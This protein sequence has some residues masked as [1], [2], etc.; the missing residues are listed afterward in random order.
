MTSFLSLRG[1]GKSFGA[2]RVLDG[3]D[4]DVEPGEF[5]C[6]LGPSGCGKTT[7]LRI[8][9]GIEHADRGRLLL[10]GQDIAGQPPAA[11]GFGVVFQSYALFPNLTAA[12]NIAYGLH[13]T[14]AL[15]REM[16][17]RSR[18]ML[19][20]VGLA[21]HADKYPVQL[22]GGQ[23]QRV[24]LARALAPNPR[25]LLLDEPLSALDAQVRA[26]LRGEIRALQKRLGIVTIMVTHD[27]EEALSMADRVVLMHDG[28]IEQAGSPG[29]LYHRPRTRFVAS[30]VGRMNMLPAT[31]L[32][33]DKVRVRDSELRCAPGALQ[34]GAQATV[35]IRP[36][37]VVVRRFGDGLGANSFAARLLGTEFLG[38]RTAARL[39]CEPLGIEIEAELPPD[40]RT[41]ETLVPSS[42]VHIELPQHAL[43]VLAH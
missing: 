31:V 26:S 36:E 2:S 29:E 10:N 7:L 11:R 24:A 42:M 39:A 30:F 21:A 43:S 8:V 1:I 17:R 13:P 19:D 12:Q 25:L 20:L 9:C 5:V 28:R 40:H 16:A 4:L 15:A 34:V 35:G 14:G 37:H 3:I 6:L 41:D 18:E 22:S 32:A 23:Q 27:Q 33:G 38:N